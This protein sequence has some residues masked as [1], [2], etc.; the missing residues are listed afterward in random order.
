MN[1][2][3]PNV[4]LA[5]DDA[6]DQDFF[7]AA[8]QR[9]FPQ[10]EVRTFNDGNELMEYLNSCPMHSLPDSIV[11]D[12]KMLPDSAPVFLRATGA[13]TR[14]CQVTKIVWSSSHLKSNMD[15]CLN[16]GANSFVIKPDTD[17]QLDDLLKSLARLTR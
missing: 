15:E 17:S 5:D 10:S 1:R 8:M 6:D 16:L 4:L 3:A 12:Y 7:R 9:V 14:Y 11:L 2:E 13:G